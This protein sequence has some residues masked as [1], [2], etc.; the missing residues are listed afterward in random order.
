MNKVIAN[1]HSSFARFARDERGT[2]LVETAVWIG[3]ITALVVGTVTAIGTDV[4]NALTT[5]SNAFNP[6]APA[7]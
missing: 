1:I 4:Q 5:V 7:P 3:L 2:Q 6:A